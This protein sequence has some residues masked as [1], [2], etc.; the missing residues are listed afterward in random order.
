MKASNAVSIIARNCVQVN[1]IWVQMSKLGARLREEREKMGLNQTD[2]GAL[3][4]IAR[5]AQA[6][7]ENDI[8]SP[9]AAYLM[10]L[11]EHG[12]DVLYLL[13]GRHAADALSEE[14][15]ALIGLYRDVPADK[16]KAL[17]LMGETLAE[18]KE[19]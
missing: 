6:N 1:I 3:G 11:A 19:T 17:H 2:F 13:T 8:R 14:E 18:R 15:S 5:T 9:D 4:G 7:Y 16:R 12:V 10:R